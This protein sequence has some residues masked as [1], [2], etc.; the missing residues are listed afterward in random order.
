MILNDKNPLVVSEILQDFI[1]RLNIQGIITIIYYS[2]KFHR[3][4]RAQ[5][6]RPGLHGYY[7]TFRVSEN[8]PVLQALAIG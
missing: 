6:A 4:I 5:Q 3:S 1:Q 2:V 8:L 7:A